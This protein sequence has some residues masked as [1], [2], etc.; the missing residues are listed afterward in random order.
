MTSGSRTC[1][2]KALQTSTL[3]PPACWTSTMHARAMASCC[4]HHI[5][6]L[7]STRLSRKRNSS[8]QIN[9]CHCSRIH[10]WYSLTPPSREVLLP[11]LGCQQGVPLF[12]HLLWNSRWNGVCLCGTSFNDIDV[13]PVHQFWHVDIVLTILPPDV[14]FKDQL[15]MDDQ[16]KPFCRIPVP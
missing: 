8:L 2:G 15:C 9:F 16:C 12:N 1:K 6:T 13:V 11:M 10:H 3:P 4:F 7:P 14:H 5:Q